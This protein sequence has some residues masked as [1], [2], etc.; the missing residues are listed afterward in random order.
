[1]DY[2]ERLGKRPHN[3]PEH[4]TAGVTVIGVGAS[5]GGLK[6]FR[7]LL[8]TLPAD[9]GFAIVLVQH[10]DPSHQSSLSEILS[11][12][13]RMPV[14]EARE[15]MPVEANHVYVIPPNTSMTIHQRVLH[16]SPRNPTAGPHMTID[17]FL[18]SLAQDCQGRS[19]GVILS[20]AGSDGSLGLQAVKEAG[21]V[22]FAQEPSTAEYTSMPHL[23]EMASGVDFVLAPEGIAAEL[24]RIARHPHFIGGPSAPNTRVSADGAG[25][26]GEILEVMRE[27][28]G[29][30]F[31]SYREKTVQ[32]RIA[33]RLALRNVS[34]LAD[35]LKLLRTD[36][37]ER[38]LLRQDLL[39]SVTNFFR[40]PKS[41]EA[42]TALVFPALV[43]DRPPGAVIRIW[44]PG[45]ATG[46]EAYSIAICLQEFLKEADLAFAVQI[47]ASDISDAAIDRARSGK[48]LENIATD[49]SPQRLER[50]FTKI[51]GGY[52]VSKVGSGA[53]EHH[54]D[55]SLR[56]Q[57][58]RLSD[59][60]PQRKGGLR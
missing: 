46:E 12:A 25:A 37:G 19:I 23:A 8:S 1:M 33:R 44:V 29:I 7:L 36:A 13:T 20:G 15:G 51:E 45:C 55:V 18:R 40:D 47:F 49:V 26:L 9:T 56:P 48:Y 43:R 6:A 24:A 11:R 27:A 32:R 30:D 14:Q 38:D 16:L 59:A 31:S 5:A 22:T 58:E 42:L 35:Y 41:F 53:K 3:D 21:G 54:P 34:S 2:Q 17:Y 4:A 60:G 50:Y 39:I 57:A 10:L 52:Q 28:T